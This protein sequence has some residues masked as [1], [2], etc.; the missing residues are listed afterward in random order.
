VALALK[1]RT[2]S[3]IIGTPSGRVEIGELVTAHE[4]REALTN[5]VK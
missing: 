3:S 5:M 1:E 4:D 2:Q